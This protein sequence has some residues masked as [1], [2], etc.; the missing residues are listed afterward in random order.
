MNIPILFLVFNRP[1]QTARVFESLRRVRPRRLFV[2]ADGPRPG[3]AGEGALCAETRRLATAVDWPC[4]VKTLFREGNLGCG[5]AVSEGIS[6]F[7]DEVEEG[8]ILEDDCL[9]NSD[10][11]EFCGMMLNRYRTEEKVGTIGGSHCLPPDLEMKRTHY[12]SKYFQMWGW[13]SWRRF[14]KHYDFSMSSVSDK[15]WQEIF[16]ATHPVPIEARFWYLIYQKLAAGGFDT[17]DFQVCFTAWRRNAVHI[18][19]SKNLVSNLGY[20][21]DAT[22]TNFASPMAEL[23]TFPLQVN[24]VLESLEPRPAI[25]DLIFYVRYLDSLHH[26]FWLEQLVAPDDRLSET[27]SELTRISRKNKQLENEIS[28]KRRQLRD[29]VYYSKRVT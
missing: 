26:T 9:P 24:D 14:W 19:P 18:M 15:G 17:W 10:F 21:S 2:A 22:H 20:G 8:I 6:W 25:D 3:R 29:A 1:S 23:S 11:F 5:Q 7:F 28:E 12:T 13:A 4:E 16:R 27:R